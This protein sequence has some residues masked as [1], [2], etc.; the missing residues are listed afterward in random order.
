MNTKSVH[1]TNCGQPSTGRYC[2]HC[3]TA[4]GFTCPSCGT[5]AEPGMRVC[6][7]CGTP[8]TARPASRQW[9]L[10]SIAPWVAV[11]F[12]SVALA[13]AVVS[14]INRGSG[15]AA[16]G[17][18]PLPSTSATPEPGQSV[19]L[20]SMSPHEAAN[21]LFNR[22]M[23]ASENGDTGEALRFVPMALKAYEKLEPLDNDALYH[24]TLIH[25]TAGDI[26]SARVTLDRL[27]QSVPNHL[28]GFML[29]YRMAGQSGDKATS[30]RAGKAFLAA[31]DAEIAVDRTEYQDHRSSI[32][33]FHKQAL[34][35]VAE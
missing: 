28:L 20:A 12:A 11:V 8:L 35:S 4:I 10:Q 7:Q 14:L 34:A 13:V 15:M 16:P 29:E 24:V 18:F 31:Y 33:S 26:D 5:Q 21:R 6:S 22:V 1:C 3:G 30:E 9:S 32:D 17:Q 25:I 19:D 2:S 23:A 27:R